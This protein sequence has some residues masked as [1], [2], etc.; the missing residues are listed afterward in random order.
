MT[1]LRN[2]SYFIGVSN[3]HQFTTLEYELAKQYYPV[4]LHFSI[5]LFY[6]NYGFSRTNIFVRIFL[7]YKIFSNTNFSILRIIRG[8]V[9]VAFYR[10]EE[11]LIMAIQLSLNRFVTS[12]NSLPN[13]KGTLTGVMPSTAIASANKEIMKAIGHNLTVRN[14]AHI[15]SKCQL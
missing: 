12:S 6:D 5:E 3:S 9:G 7:Y 8:R 13:P 14:G 4:R 15:I 1:N 2:S 11:N 10:V